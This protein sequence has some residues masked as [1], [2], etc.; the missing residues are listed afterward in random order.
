M[1][2]VR[3]L[4]AA[5]AKI[6][7]R[8]GEMPYKKSTGFPARAVAPLDMAVVFECC[9]L[10]SNLWSLQMPSCLRVM[11]AEWLLGTMRRERPAV[12]G[13]YARG[14]GLTPVLGRCETQAEARDPG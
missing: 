4:G 1:S 12:V 9:M 6:E 10:P 11:L 7:L 3:E 2:L 5:I 13:L 14:E 8:G